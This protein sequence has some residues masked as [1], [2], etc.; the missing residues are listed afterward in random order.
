LSNHLWLLSFAIEIQSTRRHCSAG[1]KSLSNDDYDYVWPN[2]V[3]R[4][5][6][7]FRFYFS[8]HIRMFQGYS[9]SLNMR[10][11]THAHTEVSLSGCHQSSQIDF[12]I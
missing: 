6:L 12:F 9:C 1:Q 2:V 11:Y 7:L 4:Q 3:N 10:I 8:T 5:E